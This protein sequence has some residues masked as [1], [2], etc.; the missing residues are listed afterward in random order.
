MAFTPGS[1]VD[2]V[3]SAHGGMATYYSLLSK[4]LNGVI[5]T[6][7]DI[8]DYISLFDFSEVH[9]EVVLNGYD[10][11]NPSMGVASD[12]IYMMVG[13]QREQELCVKSKAG[14]YADGAS[15]YADESNFYS[16]TRVYS[17]SAMQGSFNQDES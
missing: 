16:N 12:S 1:S 5:S 4:Y 13:L 10:T 11:P 14:Y 6:P 8:D 15:E 3:D 2:Q 17:T 7:P 9:R